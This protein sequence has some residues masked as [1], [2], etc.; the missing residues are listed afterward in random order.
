MIEVNGLT[1]RFD[2]FTALDGAAVTVPAAY[3]DWWAPTARVNP[4]SSAI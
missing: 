3:T 4:P 1:K 2:S